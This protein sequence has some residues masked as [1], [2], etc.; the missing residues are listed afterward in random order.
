M[1]LMPVIDRLLS[2]IFCIFE[3]SIP[4]VEYEYECQHL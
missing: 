1:T 4:H 3:T 2:R